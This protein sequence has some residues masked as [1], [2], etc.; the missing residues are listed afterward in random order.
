MTKEYWTS[1]EIVKIFSV[2]ESFI[3]ELVDGDIV[4]PTCSSDSP[5]P[6]F[7]VHDMEKL[8]IA[9]MLVEEMDVNLPGVEVILQMRQNMIAMRK[10][11]DEILDEVQRQFKKVA[12]QRIES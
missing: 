2:K 12:N 10:Q 3:C 1:T 8:R 6:V 11:F 9:K 7:S 5:T 4:C